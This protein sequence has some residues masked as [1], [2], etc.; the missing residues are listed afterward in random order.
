M[1]RVI[2]IDDHQIILDALKMMSLKDPAINVT[3]TFNHGKDAL[4]YL[5]TST[6]ETHVAVVDIAMPDISGVKLTQKIKKLRPE[7]HIL[8]LSMYEDDLIVSEM[9]K[10]GAQGY[11]LKGCDLEYLQIAIHA[12]AMNAVFFSPKIGANLIRHYVQKT[13]RVEEPQHPELTARETEILNQLLKGKRVIDISKDLNISRHTV[14]THRSN[15]MIKFNCESCVD[16][17]RY[18]LR[19]GIGDPD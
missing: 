7:C 17:I 14:N 3:A 6:E 8:A 13:N 12:V 10:N 15:I 5:R 1:I 4:D 19:E 16:L 11:V 18:C 9:L 2:G